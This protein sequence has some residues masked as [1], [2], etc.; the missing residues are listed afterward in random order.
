MVPNGRAFIH[1]LMTGRRRKGPAHEEAPDPLPKRVREKHVYVDGKDSGT[2]K[3]RGASWVRSFFDEVDNSTLVIFRVMWGLIMAWECY[4]FIRHDYNKLKVYYLL[5][6]FYPKYW[7]FFWVHA[8][9]GDGMFYHVWVMLFAS[10]GVTLGMVYHLSCI[11]FFLGFLQLILLDASL[12]LNHFHLIA[13]MA[14]ILIFL[15]ANQRF[16]IDSLVFKSIYR[17]TMPRYVLYLLRFEQIVVY[18]FAG[19]AKLNED[20]L[21]GEPIRHWLPGRALRSYNPESTFSYL[22]TVSQILL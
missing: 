4:T 18:F 19:V 8:W 12:Y 5:S 11:V 14:F 2:W 7:G 13:I 10:F 1:L 9:P 3:G 15:P 20:W 21:R 16:S 22:L 6:N 17:S